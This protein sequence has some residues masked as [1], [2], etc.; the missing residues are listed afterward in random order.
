MIC[1][2]G[3]GRASITAWT[4]LARGRTGPAAG[5][6]TLAQLARSLDVDVREVSRTARMVLGL[7]PAQARDRHFELS[8][9]QCELIGDGLEMRGQ[10][11]LIPLADV[12]AAVRPRAG[13]RTLLPFGPDR[14]APPHDL[15]FRSLRH[16]IW[17]HPDVSDDLRAWTHTHLYGRLG[18]VLQHLAAHGRT[19]VVKGCADGNRTGAGRRS[20]AP[21]ARARIRHGCGIIDDLAGFIARMRVVHHVNV[22]R[23]VLTASATVSLAGTSASPVTTS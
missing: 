1:A 7:A 9:E 10:P 23:A 8:A 15:R 17:L 13:A 4:A 20:A 2:L 5:R 11:S 16:G 22:S 14:L 12:D 3:H 19:T 21:T 6:T 18:I